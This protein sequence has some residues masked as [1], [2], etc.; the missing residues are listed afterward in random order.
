MLTLLTWTAPCRADSA[1]TPFPFWRSVRA[2]DDPRN[3]TR[4]G[5][6]VQ[7]LGPEG[8]RRPSD[9]PRCPENHRTDPARGAWGRYPA[10]D[11]G[12]GVSGRIGP[13]VHT[14]APRFPRASPHAK[15]KAQVSGLADL[16]LNN[17]LHEARSHRPRTPILFIDLWKGGF[18][19][20]ISKLNTK[21]IR[22]FHSLKIEINKQSP[23]YSPAPGWTVSNDRTAAVW[24][25]GFQEFLNAEATL[26]QVLGEL[27]FRH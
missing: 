6:R 9:A 14:E 3:V 11:D 2:R 5:E 24:D 20:E 18:G 10:R 1:N 22:L 15:V 25:R 21:L 7:D 8:H 19:A 13:C 23:G 4:A 12:Q 16:H 17:W 27:T 26:T